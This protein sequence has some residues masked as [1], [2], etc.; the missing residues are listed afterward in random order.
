MKIL[1]HYPVF[2]VGGAEMSLL[3]LT[4]VL[5]GQG[6]DVELVVTTGG[7]TL[8]SAIDPRVRLTRLRDRAA[9]MAFKRASGIADRLK[10]LPDLALYVV[11][12]LQGLLR[13]VPYL[14]RRYDASAASLQGMSTWFS[15]AVVR[16][17]VRLHW[18]RNDLAQ[19]DPDGRMI[20]SIRRDQ[21][22]IDHYVCVS[23]TA[24]DSL[25]AL[26]PDV[27]TKAVVIYNVLCI[28]QMRRKARE[29]ADPYGGY[30]AL[31]KVVTVCRLSDKAK[32]LR[33]MVAVHRRLADEGIDFYWFLV[34]D[35]P[36]RE[37]IAKLVEECGLSQRF[38]LV[39]HREDPFGYY[40]HADV[41]ATLSYYEGLAG[42]VN[43][44]KVSGLPV[45]ATRISGIDEQIV[46]G[47]NGLIADN[48]ED[49][50]VAAM[51]RIL[52]DSALRAKL[53]N[54]QLPAQLLDDELKIAAL[55]AL[56][57]QGGHAR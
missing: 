38:F 17:R 5:A 22:R 55:A 16:S 29:A 19:S 18:I 4:S 11:Y 36:D 44:A 35:G 27:A 57:S 9:G 2:N 25:V 15:C 54:D 49:A 1:F 26:V 46:D 7:G 8:E 47:Q 28:D 12:R 33:R 39:G 51:R 41:S 6:W 53:T 10:A 40:A 48:N 43:E 30:D 13:M 3:R 20:R 42:A 23:R 45:V 56:V 50:I 24:R 37:Q 34:G 31:L 52:T 32:A 14:F 21:R